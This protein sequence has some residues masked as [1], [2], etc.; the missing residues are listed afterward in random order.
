VTLK[1]RHSRTDHIQKK[2]QDAEEKVETMH[3]I[4]YCMNKENTCTGMKMYSM[5]QW[6]GKSTSNVSNKIN[7]T[8]AIKQQPATR[9]SKNKENRE[10]TNLLGSGARLGSSSLLGRDFG[11][12]RRLF[13]NN[14]LQESSTTRR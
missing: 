7:D 6:Y 10:K 11:R 8:S 2:V 12:R 5:E 9:L 1:S 4:Y 14:R 3:K 13:T